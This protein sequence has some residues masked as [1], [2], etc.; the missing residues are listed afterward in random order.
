MKVRENQCAAYIGEMTLQLAKIAKADGLNLLAY[1][2]EM[3]GLEAETAS[4]HG[5]G[6]GNTQSPSLAGDGIPPRAGAALHGAGAPLSAR[7]HRS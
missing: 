6:V 5:N 1:L 3:A 2:L 7:S 4:K